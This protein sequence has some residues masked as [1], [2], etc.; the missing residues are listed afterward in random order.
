VS[1]LRLE[2]VHKRFGG[3]HALKGVDFDLERGEV[4]AL[5]GE[6]GA[7]KST[8]IKIMSGVYPP[9]EGKV[10]LDGR[11]VKIQSP[12]HARE[13][14]IITIY[15][16]TTAY[17]DLSVL[18][19][20]F[21]GVQPRNPLGLLDWPRMRSTA[22]E[23]FER[24]GVKLPLAARMGSLS[25]AQVKLVEIAKALLQ[26]AR[27]LIMDEPSAALLAADVERLFDIIKGLRAQGVSIVYISHRVEEVFELADRVTVLRDGERV[28][29]EATARVNQ[30]W[31]INKMVGRQLTQ[32]YPRHPRKRGRP[33]LEITNLTRQDIFEDIS[34]TIHEGEIVAFAGL[35]GSG[36]SEVA[37]AIFGIDA[38]DGGTVRLLGKPLPPKPWKAVEAGLALLP[39]D[40][41][42]QGLV[43]PFSVKDNL[44]LAYLRALQRGGF[45]DEG[46]E[47]TLADR[48]I[49]SLRIRTPGPD[50]PTLNL[51]GGNQQK[52]VL[53]KWLAVNPKVL[54]L[55]EPTQGVDVGAKMEIH[56]LA[57]ELVG[58]GLGILL[59]SSDLPEVL[60]MADRILVMHR[61]RL[62]AE[63]PRGSSAEEVMRPAA[64]LKTVEEAYV[65]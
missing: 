11:E 62:V 21:M 2:G 16:E 48:F 59:I 15:Q 19:N 64:G 37:R 38:Y 25:R 23:V 8:L 20:L 60:G 58:E 45:I 6:N 51:S 42:K 40:R 32:L 24:L 34:F 39:E 17:G 31:M 46:A 3:V 35:V 14:G 26:N 28:G 57:D 61:G 12:K 50:V 33:L 54:I 13:L 29:S 55:D 18:E 4:H 56:R 9:D 43:L 49:D 7:G 10:W 41:S 65:R 63:L 30:D 47:Y 22:R 44:T 5:V 53:G 27:V 1:L 52:V 36:R